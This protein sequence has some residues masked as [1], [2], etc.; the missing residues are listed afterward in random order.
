[1]K[2]DKDITKVIFRV[3]RDGQVI[4]LFPEI[5]VVFYEDYCLSYMHIGQHGGADYRQVVQITKSATLEQ[6]ASLFE[7]LESIGYN[8][9]AYNRQTYEM[10]QIRAN[11][12]NAWRKLK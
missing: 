10:Y 11:K 1:M 7:E 12:I 9:K 8:L 6:Y 4:A 2:K 3:Y 5:A